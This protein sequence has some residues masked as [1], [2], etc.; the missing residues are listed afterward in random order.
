MTNQNLIL[1][2]RKKILFYLT[3]LFIVIA[4]TSTIYVAY[5]LKRSNTIY[6][7]VKANKR[8]WKG[9]VNQA[10]KKLGYVPIPNTQGAHVIPIGPD[11][12]MRY[13][14]DGF[15][16]P[17]GNNNR[18]LNPQYHILMLGC[19]FT[20]GDATLAEDT[21]PYLVGQ[22]LQS[23]TLNAGVCGYGIAQIMLRAKELVPIHKP[24]YLLVQY[25]P[26]LVNRA[27][28]PF[29]P[30]YFGIFPIPYFY[31]EHEL[32]I[33][34]PVFL[35]KVFSLPIDR[36]RDVPESMLNMLSFFWNVGLPL[37]IHDD[38]NMFLYTA[39]KYLGTIPGGTTVND[40]VVEYAYKEISNVAKE[41]GSKLLIVVL[42]SKPE[43]VQI[44]EE[45]FPE[46]ALIVNAHDALL[47]PLSSFDKETY[48]KEYAH[49]RGTPPV[50]VDTHPNKIAHKIIAKEIVKMIKKTCL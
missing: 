44:K 19:S 10:D 24:D 9:N 8:G 48:K 32:A 45:L 43:P 25:S 46:D 29:S 3:I 23:K 5:T 30:T 49:W 22:Y 21:Y 26:W 41:N 20:Y 4:A 12:P 42:G 34:P 11:V 15:R 7:Y 28:K 39:K 33:H 1:N 14:K 2:K 40:K 6:S 16:I 18:A 31:G 47:K 17:L 50:L 27:R 13:D 35:T 38:F 37:F 36:Y